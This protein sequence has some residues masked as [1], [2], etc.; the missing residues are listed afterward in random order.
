MVPALHFLFKVRKLLR[1]DQRKRHKCHKPQKHKQNATQNTTLV[2]I[3]TLANQQASLFSYNSRIIMK[4]KQFANSLVF[5]LSN[6]TSPSANSFIYS[7]HTWKLYLIDKQ[8]CFSLISNC[9]CN[10]PTFMAQLTPIKIVGFN[11]CHNKH[12]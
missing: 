5:L 3:E 10:C 7:H 1:Y 12:Y 8:S 4:K 9:Q 6:S 2:A 11:S